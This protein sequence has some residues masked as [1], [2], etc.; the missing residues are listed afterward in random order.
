MLREAGEQGAKGGGPHPRAPYGV[1][2]RRARESRPAAAGRP[3]GLPVRVA[4]LPLLEAQ[5]H[6]VLHVFAHP[7]VL[8]PTEEAIDIV[9]RYEALRAHIT[10]PSSSSSSPS[11]DALEKRAERNVICEHTPRTYSAICCCVFT[12]DVAVLSQSPA[13]A[14]ASGFV[15]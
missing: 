8:D 7:D 2:F 5:M 4:P 12:S 14:R 6:A 11:A 13:R 15:R 10:S 9:A 3:A 1:L